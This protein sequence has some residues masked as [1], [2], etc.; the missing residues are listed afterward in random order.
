MRFILSMVARIYQPGCK[1]DYILILEGEQGVLKSTACG[2]LAG[3]WFS[4]TLPDI[5]R[6]KEAMEHLRG[7]WLVEIA[8]ATTTVAL[9]WA[10][11]D[12]G[13]TK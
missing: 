9:K 11:H 4:R 10:C 7:V 12:C 1:A 13:P 3:K 5:T 2:I 6:D 8:P